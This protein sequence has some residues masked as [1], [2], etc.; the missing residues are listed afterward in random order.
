M[1]C[2]LSQKN[3]W[4]FSLRKPNT[5]ANGV[6]WLISGLLIL[7][8]LSVYPKGKVESNMNFDQILNTTLK[9]E[10]GLNKNEIGGGVSNYG[11]KQDTYNAYAK[12]KGIASKD[13]RNLKYGDV[14]GIYED[15]YYKQPKID[16]LPSG[17]IQGL[18]FDWGVNAGT[19]TVIK[20]LQEIVGTKPDGQIGKKT[21]KAVNDYISKNGEDSLAFSILSSR[22]NHYNELI[23]QDPHKYGSYEKNWM[24]RINYLAQKYGQ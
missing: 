3:K 19:V 1:K 7:L 9:L 5:P 17:K 13:V 23:R 6:R 10:G 21:I 2:L 18:V 12:E 24:N 22:S 8:T 16:Q 14:R 4:H 20:K 11:V 15:K